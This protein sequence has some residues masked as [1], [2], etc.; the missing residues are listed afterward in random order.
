MIDFTRNCIVKTNMEKTETEK[1]TTSSR[2]PLKMC[3]HCNNKKCK[4]NGYSLLDQCSNNFHWAVFGIGAGAL[5]ML[6]TGIYLI[7][8]IIDGNWA[9]WQLPVIIVIVYIITVSIFAMV[10]S[11]KTVKQEM[12]VDEDNR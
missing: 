6:V 8:R 7:V 11:L 2:R 1:E 9:S 10:F 3:A 4:E 5:F 12:S